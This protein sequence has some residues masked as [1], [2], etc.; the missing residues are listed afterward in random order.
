[1]GVENV[2]S[3]F[4]LADGVVE[5]YLHWPRKP[6]I[7]TWTSANAALSCT[8]LELAKP[9][10]NPVAMATGDFENTRDQYFW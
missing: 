5:G 2:K 4:V 1:M 3:F 8:A 9:T 10:L 7:R 6:A